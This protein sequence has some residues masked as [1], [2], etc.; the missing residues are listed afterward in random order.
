MR[1]KEGLVRSCLAMEQ[2]LT[3]EKVLAVRTRRPGTVC[4]I[5]PRHK[6]EEKEKM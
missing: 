6:I 4:V 3:G 2:I 1:R 5:N